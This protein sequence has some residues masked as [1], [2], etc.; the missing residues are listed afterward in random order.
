MLITKN[1]SILT[2]H[3]VDLAYIHNIITNRI[4]ECLCK[5]FRKTHKG[6]RYNIQIN[7]ILQG[8]FFYFYIN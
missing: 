1:Q 6:N 3:C 2:L 5:P 8:I 4:I 7:A